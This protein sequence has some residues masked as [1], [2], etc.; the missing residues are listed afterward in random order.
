[1]NR[2]SRLLE[3]HGR[4][5]VRGAPGVGKT[6][7]AMELLDR[8]APGR[9][10]AWCDVRQGDPGDHADVVRQWAATH[11]DG[12]IVVDGADAWPDATD[13]ITDL[14]SAREPTAALLVTTRHTVHEELPVVVLRP[15]ALDASDAEGSDPVLLLRA[16]A[17]LRAPDAELATA[18][19]V[20]LCERVGGLPLGIRLVAEQ[21]RSTPVS[22]LVGGAMTWTTLEDA[23]TDVL[24][25]M[26]EE[27]RRLFGAAINLPVPF[28][29]ALLDAASEDLVEDPGCTLATLVDRGLVELDDTHAT[30]HYSVPEPFR[31][32]GR[33][34]LPSDARHAVRHRT[35]QHIIE[36]ARSVLRRVTSSSE[37]VR[38]LQRELPWYRV[39]L[40]QLA[41]EGED[42]AALDLVTALDAPLYMAGRWIEKQQLLRT[43][44]AIPGERSRSR[45][46]AHAYRGR[47]G[48]LHQLDERH[49]VTARVMAAEI[50]AVDVEMVAAVHLGIL[51]WW[52]G[53][54]DDALA[55]FAEVRECADAPR[56]ARIDA[57]KFS[58]VVAV[59]SGAI[60]SGMSRLFEL[61]ADLER[62]PPSAHQRA[63]VAHVRMYAGHCLRQIG[64]LEGALVELQSAADMWA[65]LDNVASAVHVEAGLADV[66]ADLGRPAEAVRHATNALT[67]ADRGGLH[68]YDGWTHCT[69]AR[70]H[71]LA[72]DDARARA[73][74]HVAVRCA[75]QEWPG[76]RSRVA[77]ELAWV[78]HALGEHAAASRLAAL[79]THLTDRRELPFRTPAESVR[80][81]TA[82][83]AG[84]TSA[85]VGGLSAAIASLGYTA[86]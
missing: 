69:L 5:S 3:E 35:A 22:E 43:A 67:L 1:M 77:A 23:A 81:A 51:R 4:A 39:T 82:L 74:V 6:R 13:V 48:L 47:P 8:L 2:L 24:E 29:R 21:L 57:D 17:G 20:V 46:L 86:A 72:G 40:D 33:T 36:R 65:E 83:D 44:L 9:P 80:L 63:G 56:Q 68:V 26:G 75:E 54:Y 25:H 64:E 7:L 55:S 11:P 53:R 15:L 28:D 10:V 49:L 19:A 84:A 37:L 78:T 32:A 60:D 73:S 12:L 14:V 66:F 61:A 45:A 41:V 71:V 62:R 38:A 16:L 27:A 34:L 85:P 18:D 31:G 58:G 59:A 70:A 52:E 50:G 42:V 30:A 76:E 79:T